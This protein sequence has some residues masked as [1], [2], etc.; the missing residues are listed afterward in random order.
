MR[1]VT[2]RGFRRKHP[3]KL[4]HRTIYHWVVLPNP[5]PTKVLFVGNTYIFVVIQQMTE[6]KAPAA[7]QEEG[8]SES[9][10]SRGSTFR[11]GAWLTSGGIT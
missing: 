10:T 6:N 4:N 1:I 3:A 7:P 5:R 11:G 2:R 9:L 8:V